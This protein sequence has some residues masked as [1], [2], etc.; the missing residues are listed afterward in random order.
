[1]S[2]IIKMNIIAQHTIIQQQC[3]ILPDGSMRMPG[4]KIAKLY[5]TRL[6]AIVVILREY[7]AAYRAI[8]FP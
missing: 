6:R 7:Q 8:C 1:M 2:Y 3:S 4:V 5:N